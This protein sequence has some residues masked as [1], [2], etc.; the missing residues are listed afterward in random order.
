MKQKSRKDKRYIRKQIKKQIPTAGEKPMTP[1]REGK[2]KPTIDSQERPSQTSVIKD[3]S[4]LT[5]TNITRKEGMKPIK[6]PI[7]YPKKRKRKK[8]K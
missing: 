2:M 8:R 5:V 6:K 4:S 1:K 7:R 3:D